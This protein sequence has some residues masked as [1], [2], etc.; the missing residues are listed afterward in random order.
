M[1]ARAKTVRESFHADGKVRHRTLANITDL[2]DHAI[3][4]VRQA[5]RLGHAATP[6]QQR[7]VIVGGYCVARAESV[8]FSAGGVGWAIRG[9]RAGS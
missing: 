2:P 3:Q 9:G 5:L 8:F 4:A 7:R 6:A 1:D